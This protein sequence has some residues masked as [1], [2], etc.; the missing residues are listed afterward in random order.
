L[1]WIFVFSISFYLLSHPNFVFRMKSTRTKPQGPPT[2]IQLR[3]F[4]IIEKSHLPSLA[5]QNIHWYH[6]S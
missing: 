5:F 2:E 3:K 6:V 4:S 1:R